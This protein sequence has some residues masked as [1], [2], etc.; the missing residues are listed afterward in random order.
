MSPL[1]QMLLAGSHPRMGNK[2]LWKTQPEFIDYN[3]RDPVRKCTSQRVPFP[4]G[5]SFAC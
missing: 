3:F 1:G 5:E 2:T 4:D